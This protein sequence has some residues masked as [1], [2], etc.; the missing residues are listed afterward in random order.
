MRILLKTIATTLLAFFP[1]QLVLMTLFVQIVAYLSYTSFYSSRELLYSLCWIPFLTLPYVVTGKRFLY[2]IVLTIVFIGNFFNLIHI[3]TTNS[4]INASSLFIILNT[5]WSEATEFMDLQIKFRHL[6]LIPFVAI[7]IWGII[8][9]MPNVTMNKSKLAICV[10][11]VFLL[12]L[13]IFLGRRAYYGRHARYVFPPTTQAFIALTEE[14]KSYKALKKREIMPIEANRIS[15]VDEPC[16]FVLIIGESCSRNHMSLYDYHKE[17][18]PLLENR[19][20]IVCFN[21]VVSSHS[22]TIKSI[23]TFLTEANLEN[24]KDAAQS[25]SLLD[26]FHAAK[27]KTYWLSNQSP[28]G[29]ADNAI[30]NIAKTS[31]K[32][33]FTNLYANGSNESLRITAYDENIFQ[34]LV[35]TLKEPYTSKFIVVHLMGSHSAYDKRYPIDFK[36]FEKYLSKNEK[37]INEYDNSIFYNDFVVDSL[38]NI[39]S[40][41]CQRNKE[42]ICSAIYLS[43]HGQNVYD[44]NDAVGHTYSHI[45]PKANVEVPFIVW[46]APH[47]RSLYPHKYQN[48]ENA[49]EFPFVTDDLFHSVIDLTDIDCLLFEKNR[50]LFHPDFNVKRKRILEDNHDYDLF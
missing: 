34:P 49:I 4:P 19:T 46:T 6:L 42:T 21:N 50:S 23:L 27:F 11:F 33:I 1:L 26:I 15:N 45:I 18:T 8:K 35:A 9:K 40:D 30:Y 3:L 44:E 31:D 41:Y 7:F 28:I 22:N 20:D 5:N 48:I 25:I 32:T 14:M 47:F 39:L 43:D 17:T 10:I 12:L 38:F 24:K 36:K 37:L 16:V 13:T 2:I 29:F